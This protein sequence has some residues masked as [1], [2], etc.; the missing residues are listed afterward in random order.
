MGVELRWCHPFVPT[1]RVGKSPGGAF[2]VEYRVW[3]W[4][5]D[6]GWITAR[7]VARRGVIE[8][9]EYPGG[10][11]FPLRRKSSGG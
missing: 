3:G 1:A 4:G 10:R 11:R 8:H 2:W 9:G 5:V 6:R 7:G